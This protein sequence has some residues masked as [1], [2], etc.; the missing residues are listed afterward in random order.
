MNFELAVMAL[1]GLAR[2]P[3]R[4]QVEKSEIVIE[5][6]PASFR[7]LAR[8]LLLLGGSA[9]DSGEAFELQPARHLTGESPLLRLRLVP[10]DQLS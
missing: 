10:G 7:E 9:P 4:I 1:E 3:A 6:T 2:E 5:A 8:I